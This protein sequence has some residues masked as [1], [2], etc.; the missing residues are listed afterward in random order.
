MHLEIN[1]PLLSE[2]EQLCRAFW[3]NENLQN[4]PHNQD[5]AI[6]SQIPCSQPQRPENNQCSENA[7][8]HIELNLDQNST[9]G[10][11]L[12]EQQ[13]RHNNDMRTEHDHSGLSRKC[14][15]HS[16]DMH[17]YCRSTST[18]FGNHK[19][20]T[21]EH[22][23]TTEHE[24][25][26]TNWPKRTSKVLWDKST[27]DSSFLWLHRMAK[28]GHINALCFI[29]VWWLKDKPSRLWL[30]TE[31]DDSLSFTWRTNA[32]KICKK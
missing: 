16:Q 20:K 30:W 11:Y 8:N 1:L 29:G 3:Q 28:I 5:T 18:D 27:C 9:L 22:R 15:N 2:L 12:E 10:S 26:Q 24:L 17:Q 31:L 25:S 6:H 19:S 13:Y 7:N 23:D 14:K 21:F 4:H 32:P